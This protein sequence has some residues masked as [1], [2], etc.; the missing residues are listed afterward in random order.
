MWLRQIALVAHDLEPVVDRLEKVLG[1]KVAYR[2]PE[3]AVFGLV[4]AVMPVGG[5]FLEVVQPVKAAASPP[6][7]WS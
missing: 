6:R 7:R 4:N 3:V 1:L 2:D 5:E